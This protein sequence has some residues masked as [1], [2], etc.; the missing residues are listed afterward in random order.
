METEIVKWLGSDWE[1]ETFE[2]LSK[3]KATELEFALNGWIRIY[4]QPER[5]NPEDHVAGD[6]NMICDSLNSMET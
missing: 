6:G 5:L 1:R 4:E 2:S 3:R